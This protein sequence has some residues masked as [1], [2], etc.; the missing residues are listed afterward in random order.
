V[1]LALKGVP[2]HK[3]KHP[4][5]TDTIGLDL[6]PSTI[7]SVPREGEARLEQFCLEAWNEHSEPPAL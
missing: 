1:Q 7:A 5:G 3:P 6:G 4:L 2:S